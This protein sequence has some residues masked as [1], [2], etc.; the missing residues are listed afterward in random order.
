MKGEA[1]SEGVRGNKRPTL[2]KSSFFYLILARRGAEGEGR[3]L[4]RINFLSLPLQKTSRS[5]R[6]VDDK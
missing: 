2:P 4:H 1:G 6:E 3:K 5:L